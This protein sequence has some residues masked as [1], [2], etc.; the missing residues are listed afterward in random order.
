MR[1]YC[2]YI[3]HFV[4]FLLHFFEVRTRIYYS[5]AEIVS[6]QCLIYFQ[7][8]I[9]CVLTSFYNQWKTAASHFFRHTCEWI[10]ILSYDSEATNFL[11]SFG[12]LLLLA[13]DCVFLGIEETQ[14]KT[15]NP[16]KEQ[17]TFLIRGSILCFTT[18]WMR[19]SYLYVSI[20]FKSV[21]LNWFHLTNF[22]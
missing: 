4:H 18:F 1:Y 16:S 21:S 13:E 11:L 17:R 6:I 5:D 7:H 8:V 15:P 20:F 12:L 19:I 10:N 2:Y 9:Y 14:S 3:L 22:A